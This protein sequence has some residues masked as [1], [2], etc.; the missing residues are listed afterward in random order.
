MDS[1]DGFYNFLSQIGRAYIEQ[2]GILFWDCKA[3]QLHVLMVGNADP[4]PRYHYSMR[5]VDVREAIRIARMIGDGAWHP[6][7]I[8]HTHVEWDNWMPSEHDIEVIGRIN[9]IARRKR[10]YG[11]VYHPRTGRTT[12]YTQK[13]VIDVVRI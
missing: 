3:K 7:G 10:W 1:Y 12:R 5:G 4:N 9:T 13:G 2:C 8:M 6:I 11:I